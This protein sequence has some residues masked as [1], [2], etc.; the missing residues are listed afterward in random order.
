MKNKNLRLYYNNIP[1]KEAPIPRAEREYHP[2]WERYALP[3]GN[4]YL[5]ACV[6]GYTDTERIQI[7]ENSLANPYRSGWHKLGD[8]PP[9]TGAGLNSFAEIYIDFGHGD[10]KDYERELDIEDAIARVSY[11]CSGTKYTREYFTSYPDKVLVMRFRA[12]KKGAVNLYLRPEIPHLTDLTLPR[13]GFAKLGEVKVDECGVTL[14]GEME[15]Y[16]IKYE[17]KLNVNTVGGRCEPTDVGIRVIDANEVVIIFACATN[18]RLESRVFTEPDPK[19]KLAPYPHPHAEVTKRIEN[20]EKKGYDSLL[21]DHLKDYRALFDRVRISIGEHDDRPTDLLL[22]EYKAGRTTRHLEM[23]LYQY[24]RYL[25]IASSRKGCL[26]ANLQGIWC[27]HNISPWSAGYWHNINLQM[28]YWPAEVANLAETFIPYAD[29]NRA[30]M[31][32]A[33]ENADRS[34]MNNYPKSFTTP[35]TNGWII[36]TGGWP[37]RIEGFDRI[38][39]SGPGTGS[40]TA[41]LFWEYY[42]YTRDEDFLR[43]TAYPVLREMSIFLSKTLT[44]VDGLLLVH[45]SASPEIEVG[46]SY[47]HTTGSTFDQQMVYESYKRTV[48]AAEILGESDEFIEKIK[49][50]ITKLSPAPIGADGQIKEFREEIHY[51]DIGEREHRHISHLLGM[52]PGTL[53]NK[54]TP[55]WLRAAEVTLTLR[56]DRSHTWATAHRQCLWARAR[57][58]DRAMDLIFSLIEHVMMPNLWGNHPPFQIDG[59]FGYVAG[60]SEMLIQ[61]QAG[62]IDLL[63]ALPKEW[64]NGSFSGL[65]ARGGF[66]VGCVWENS[67]PR[68]V[69]VR[70][71]VGGVLKIELSD[72]DSATVTKNGAPYAAEHDGTVLTLNTERGDEIKFDLS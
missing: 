56:G 66:E 34:V 13:D 36:G 71:T 46:G 39:H 16:G 53:I 72:V 40:I 44:E 38:G 15:Y 61:S 7:T 45:P 59:N 28:N 69:T 50:D 49:C 43:D 31:A 2:I 9:Y 22:E 3:L 37:Y 63:P 42:D 48:E 8:K 18:Y 21:R 23:L 54:D 5:G 1:P 20:A 57:R 4:G 26:P 25:L 52:Y 24:G 67:S 60:V 27:A 29:Y 30:Y 6:F 19:M 32:A 47:Y 68:E 12:D 62:Y 17:G 33:R 41:L 70:S 10:V 35:G 55:E 65:M 58:A 11:E 64:A 14:V 51:A